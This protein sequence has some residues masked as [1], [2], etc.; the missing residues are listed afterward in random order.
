MRS[1]GVSNFPDPTSD[2]HGR[3]VFNLQ[4]AGLNPNSPQLRTKAQQCQSLLHPTQL[5]PVTH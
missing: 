2:S 3:P 5:P 1:H 4:A